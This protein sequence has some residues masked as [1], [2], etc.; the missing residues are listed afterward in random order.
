[1]SSSFDF[2]F[3]FFSFLL[4]TL[5]YVHRH[6]I[7]ICLWIFSPSGFLTPAVML[8]FYLLFHNFASGYFTELLQS[9]ALKTK[10]SLSERV[11]SSHDVMSFRHCGS[12]AKPNTSAELSWHPLKQT[13]YQR[14][15]HT[16]T[17]S[18][19]WV[20]SGSMNK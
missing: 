10:G 14:N 17:S 16:H 3:N 4:R 19:H 20:C 15:K 12:E 13:D 18:L 7:S 11:R 6:I 8:E 5:L 9:Q 2:Y 1:M